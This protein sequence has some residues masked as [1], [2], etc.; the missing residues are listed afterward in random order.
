MAV[1]VLFYGSETWVPAKKT[2]DQYTSIGDEI[3]QPVTECTRRD[4]LCNEDIRKAVNVFN[5]QD[6]NAEKKERRTA[7]L[8]RMPDGR[9]PKEVCQYKPVG[10][11]RTGGPRK[12]L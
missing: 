12:H 10:Q 1:P 5:I 6:R 7:H 4:R 8:N 11:Q 2:Y 3:L 9:L